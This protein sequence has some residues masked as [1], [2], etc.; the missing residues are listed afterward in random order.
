MG[1]RPG[2]AL[3]SVAGAEFDPRSRGSKQVFHQAIDLEDSQKRGF[4]IEAES[5]MRW[6]D[7]KNDRRRRAWLEADR[8][9]VDSVLIGFTHWLHGL[10]ERTDLL[11]VWTEDAALDMP[12]LTAAYEIIGLPIPWWRTNCMCL[13]TLKLMAKEPPEYVGEK[14]SDALD[15]AMNQVLD[16]QEIAETVG[17][18]EE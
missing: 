3:L 1:T 13:R 12:V 10:E 4:R 16:L 9:D 2:A 6:L 8:I 5:V 11:A 7:K 18:R 17:W 15:V 14:P